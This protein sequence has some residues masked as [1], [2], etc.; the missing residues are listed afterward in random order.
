MQK[1]NFTLVAKYNLWMNEKL[2]A[3]VAQLND[4]DLSQD[5]CAL[6]DINLTVLI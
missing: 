5:K 6:V 4:H 2:F 3:A 1:E